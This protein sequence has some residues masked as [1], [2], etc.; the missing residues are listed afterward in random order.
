VAPADLGRVWEMIRALAAFERLDD[1]LTGSPEALG[2]ALFE[3]PARLEGLVAARGDRLV[4]YA[5]F[6]LTYSSFRTNPRLWLE[7]L[8]VEDAARGCGA[9]EALLAEFCRL[10]L[11]RGCHRA[12]WDVLD[13]NPA[14]GFY[15][16]MGAVPSDTGWT[17]Y[18]MEAEAM[19]RLVGRA[20]A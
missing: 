3:E 18:G 12:D 19:R 8:F 10:A 20:R 16:R 5:L 1:L 7:D 6:H 9:G 14:R 13:W 15:E 17:R 4:G 2:R 11:A